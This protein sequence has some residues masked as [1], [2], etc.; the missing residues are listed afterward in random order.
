[1]PLSGPAV[2][3]PSP[4]HILERSTPIPPARTLSNTFA[5][6]NDRQAAHLGQDT[7]AG[8]SREQAGQPMIVGRR[9]SI[10]LALATRSSCRASGR[11]A[12]RL[13][14][15]PTQDSLRNRNDIAT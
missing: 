2:P 9:L 1:M 12:A 5:W 11:V 4:S 10:T 15:L 7:G 8:R 6:L 14:P 3:R 13:S